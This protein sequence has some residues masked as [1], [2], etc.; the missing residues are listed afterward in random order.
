MIVP[1][2]S[3]AHELVRYVQKKH[4]LGGNRT[5]V[6]A[7]LELGLPSDERSKEH[8]SVNSLEVESLRQIAGYCQER[9]QKG[10]G[11]VALSSTKVRAFTS[12]GK[13]FGVDLTYD[14]AK[15]VWHF[16]GKNGSQEEAYRHRP[17]RDPYV[18]RLNS[19]SHCGV[20]FVR[21]MDDYAKTKFARRLGGKKYHLVRVP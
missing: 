8:L 17:V 3:E 16:V 4:R 2:F 13:K 14:A 1:L 7:Y 6:A 10:T 15:S 19:P 5:A 11:D 20:E 21:A 18:E 9:F 12:A